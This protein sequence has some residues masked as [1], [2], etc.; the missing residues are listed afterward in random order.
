MIETRFVK[1]SEVSTSRRAPMGYCLAAFLGGLAD[2]GTLQAQ[3]QTA[4]LRLGQYLV[5]AGVSCSFLSN[6]FLL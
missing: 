3:P 6:I 4:A 2:D 1:L 5:L